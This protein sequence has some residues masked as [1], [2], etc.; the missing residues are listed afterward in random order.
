[1]NACKCD[2]NVTILRP[3]IGFKRLEGNY[4]PLP[5]YEKFGDAGLDLRSNI[6]VLIHPGKRQ[7]IP[8][9]F[10]VKLPYDYEGQIRS[11]SGLAL[12]H[13]ITV[14]N[15]PG[16]IDAGFRGELCVIL[17]NMNNAA[18]HVTR[19]MR[20]AQLVIAPVARAVISEV[21]ELD[22][23]DRGLNGFGSTGVA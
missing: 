22:T 16:T 8:I 11:R 6:D 7:P 10:A 9:G 15:S 21:E 14:L 23:T 2:V 5:K 4:N 13:G 20:V 3:N 1:M 12:R 17:I 18:F 19:G